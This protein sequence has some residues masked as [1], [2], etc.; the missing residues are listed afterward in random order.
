MDPV[1]SDEDYRFHEESERIRN[2]KIRARELQAITQAKFISGEMFDLTATS[3][4]NEFGYDHTIGILKYG[5]NFP[6]NKFIIE[7]TKIVVGTITDKSDKRRLRLNC[8]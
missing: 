2:Q 1:F 8:L 3:L 4:N 6:L 7:L 5:I